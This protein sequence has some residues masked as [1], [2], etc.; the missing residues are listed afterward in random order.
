MNN[1]HRVEMILLLGDILA[2]SFDLHKFG[3]RMD[4]RLVQIHLLKDSEIG[5]TLFLESLRNL[6]KQVQS[7]VT[8]WMVWVSIFNDLKTDAV[9]R[10]WSSTA[11]RRQPGFSTNGAK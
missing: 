7:G 9:S 3:A 1:F 5:T 11:T 2:P 8:V 6:H 4:N 10:R